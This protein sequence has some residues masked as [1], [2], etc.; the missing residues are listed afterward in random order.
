MDVP[1]IHAIFADVARVVPADF[2]FVDCMACTVITVSKV[3]SATKREASETT[4]ETP[5]VNS[6]VVSSG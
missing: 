3:E 2:D 1:A 4:N 5:S 6:G